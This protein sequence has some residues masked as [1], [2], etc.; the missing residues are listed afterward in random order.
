MRFRG[1]LVVFKD[2]ILSLLW[3]KDTLACRRDAVGCRM[4]SGSRFAIIAAPSLDAEV[5]CRVGKLSSQD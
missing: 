2:V 3:S 1:S 4:G 5:Q